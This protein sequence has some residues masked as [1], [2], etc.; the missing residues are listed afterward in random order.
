MSRSSFLMN[1]YHL[2]LHPWM[3]VIQLW[4]FDNFYVYLDTHYIFSLYFMHSILCCMLFALHFIIFVSYYM[5]LLH[6]WISI[7]YVNIIHILFLF[8][9][10]MILHISLSI[11]YYMGNLHHDLFFYIGIFTSYGMD[12]GFMIILY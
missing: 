5:I 1:Y 12:Q 8:I 9:P 10:L 11:F 4:Y 3:Y 6:S 2:K 7:L